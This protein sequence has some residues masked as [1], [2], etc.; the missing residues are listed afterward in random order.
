VSSDRAAIGARLADFGDCDVTHQRI[1]MSLSFFDGGQQRRNWT[2][3][4]DSGRPLFE[5]ST[6]V[7]NTTANAFSYSPS[8]D[9][10]RFLI[11]A[12]A[13][14]SQPVLNVIVNWEGTAALRS[15]SKL[16]CHRESKL[17]SRSISP[18]PAPSDAQPNIV[19]C[20]RRL[21]S[22]PPKTSCGS[23]FGLE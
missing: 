12:I 22:A 8:A 1:P 21:P 17:A 5:F 18:S 4:G 16:D 6:I 20:A 9:G 7:T 11:K 2:G 15:P 23:E 14:D 19:S 3:F 10:Q 13:G